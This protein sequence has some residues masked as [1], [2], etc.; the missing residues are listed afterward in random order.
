[1][2]GEFAERYNRIDCGHPQID[3]ARPFYMGA[4]EHGHYTK[5]ANKCGQLSADIGEPFDWM[6][7]HAHTRTRQIVFGQSRCRCRCTRKCICKCAFDLYVRL[8]VWKCGDYDV[9]V[10]IDYAVNVYQVNCIVARLLWSE[11]F[12]GL[13][14]NLMNCIAIDKVVVYIFSETVI[15]HATM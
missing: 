7:S 2:N 14:T 12:A 1:M 3:D 6:Q 10:I 9:V 5:L 8:R 4:W 11:R 15:V 13:V